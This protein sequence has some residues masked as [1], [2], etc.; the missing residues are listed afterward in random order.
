MSGLLILSSIVAFTLWYF[1]ED[2]KYIGVSGLLFVL[3]LLCGSPWLIIKT[4]L[5]VAA[6]MTPIGIL[7]GWRN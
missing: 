6:V 3:G 2:S 1:S 5:F 4:L 7:T